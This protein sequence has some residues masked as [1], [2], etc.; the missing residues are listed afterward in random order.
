MK[1]YFPWLLI[2]FILVFNSLACQLTTAIPKQSSP[3]IVVTPPSTASLP[4]KN[5]DL[6][7]QDTLLTTLYEKVDPGIVSIQVLSDSGG[8]LGSG[9][10]FDKLGH[11]ITNYHVVEGAQDL[12]VDF[13]SGIKVRG[14]VV[15]KDLDSDIAVINI[16]APAEALFPLEMGDSDQIKVGQAVIAIG[17]PFGLTGTMTTG[18]VSARGRTLDS[19]RQ[20]PEGGTFTAGG[21]IQTDAAINP[22][23]SGGPLLDLKG[24]VIGINRAIRTTTTTQQGEPAN[25]GVGFAVPVN[26][27][28]RV[29]PVLIE[30]GSYDYPYLGISTREEISLIEQ[31][32]LGLSQS[33]GAYILDVVPGGPADQAGLKGGNQNTSISGLPGGGDLI[34]AIDNR[35]VRVFGDMLTYLMENKS[36]G[37]TIHLTILRANQQKEVAIT[38]GKRP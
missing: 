37:D 34:T 23:N 20:T 33:S 25:S 3:I 4:Q 27:V 28:K 21:L 32:A 8:S 35:P 2:I 38:L 24:R 29:V 26:I 31:E 13:V 6:E 7:Y 9:F 5:P 11:V 17:N 1:R 16:S 19:L 14:K 36:P 15:G 22:G 18:I 30:K 12:E 10:V